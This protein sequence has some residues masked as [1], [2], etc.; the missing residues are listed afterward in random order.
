MR[1]LLLFVAFLAALCLS[2]R[3]SRAGAPESEIDL[4][5]MGPGDHL[6]TRGGHAAL[7]VAEIEDGELVR[8]T[9]YNYGDTDWEDP[10]LVPH[11]LRGNLTFFL[12]DTGSI[13]STLQEYGVK[14]GREITR[15][16]LNL[17]AEQAAIRRRDCSGERE[18]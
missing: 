2:P 14:Q 6:Y 17:S 1:R 3:T 9:V 7:M 4:L 10:L 8:S 5:V 15:Q 13:E 12:S 16:R 18:E 11:F